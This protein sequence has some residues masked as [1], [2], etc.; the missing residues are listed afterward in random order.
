MDLKTGGN[1]LKILPVKYIG[2]RRNRSSALKYKFKGKKYINDL[3][4]NQNDRS[5]PTTARGT[6]ECSLTENNVPKT[7]FIP[8]KIFVGNLPYGTEYFDLRQLFKKYG[9]VNFASVFQ[10]KRINP[11]GYGFVTFSTESAA[12]NAIEASKCEGIFLGSKRLEVAPA[13]DRLSV[14]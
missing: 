11:P 2:T 7:N 8:K 12:K 4:I 1:Y 14:A 10:S 13:V 3:D 5:V 9:A 6:K